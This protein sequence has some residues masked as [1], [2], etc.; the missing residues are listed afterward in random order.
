[1]FGDWCMHVAHLAPSPSSSKG[2]GA[3]RLGKPPHVEIHFGI[4]GLVSITILLKGTFPLQTFQ[5]LPFHGAFS[6]GVHPKLCSGVIVLALP[7]TNA[8]WDSYGCRDACGQLDMVGGMV[9]PVAK[10]VYARVYKYII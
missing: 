6:T 5:V 2:P 4:E 8:A 7:K 9:P 10:D 1:M 3:P